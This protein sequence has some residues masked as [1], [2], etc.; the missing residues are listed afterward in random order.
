MRIHRRKI[1]RPEG[2]LHIAGIGNNGVL[3]PNGE[4]IQPER[5]TGPLRFHGDDGAHRGKGEQRELLDHK[6]GERSLGNIR[7]F[8][9]PK[10]R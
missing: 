7:G 2:L 6:L 10:V 9:F 5:M 4:R 3:Q 1:N 8:R